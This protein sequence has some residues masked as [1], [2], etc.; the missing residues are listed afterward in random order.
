MECLEQAMGDTTNEKAMESLIRQRADQITSI[1]FVQKSKTF[2]EKF[3]KV[4]KKVKPIKVILPIIQRGNEKEIIERVRELKKLSYFHI[5]FY[6]FS[7]GNTLSML[8]TGQP[9][10]NK[11]DTDKFVKLNNNDEIVQQLKDIDDELTDLFDKLEEIQTDKAV[12]H[13]LLIEENMK[14]Q[15]SIKDLKIQLN[16]TSDSEP[17]IPEFMRKPITMVHSQP[18]SPAI[19]PRED[20]PPLELPE[21]NYN[22]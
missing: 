18:P 13:Q 6:V 10:V 15:K 14:L 1:E 7:D 12:E 19:Q 5:N 4:Q 3:V 20:F 17:E 2:H 21:F 8:Q 16:D 22:I 9:F 11:F